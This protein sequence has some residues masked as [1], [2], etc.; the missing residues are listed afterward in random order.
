KRIPKIIL[1]MPADAGPDTT[2]TIDDKAVASTSGPIEVDPGEHVV[3]ATSP[4]ATKPFESRVKLGESGE[5]TLPISLDG[6]SDKPPPPPPPPPPPSR[7]DTLAY[8][9]LGGGA[10]FIVGGVVM[11]VVRK[12]DINDINSKCPNGVC[13]T[14]AKSAVDSDQSQAKLF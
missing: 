5:I 6:S 1:K 4:T 10:A 8:I 3:R 12:G 14:S 11:L 13:P 9:A 2:V 7:N